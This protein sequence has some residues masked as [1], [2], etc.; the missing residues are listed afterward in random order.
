MGEHLFPRNAWIGAQ[1][2]PVPDVRRLGQ[3]E[4]EKAA[5]RHDAQKG[6]P[7]DLKFVSRD[8]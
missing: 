3:N 2:V 4:I 8:E 6:A 1:G 7:L 5:D